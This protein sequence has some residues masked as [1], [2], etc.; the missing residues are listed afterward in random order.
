[1]SEENKAVIARLYAELS[2][3]NLDAIDTALADNFIEHEELPPGIPPGRE[4]VTAFF[5]V[6]RSAFPDL[7]MTPDFF[8][9]EG[10]LVTA[11]ATATGTHRGE[12]QGIPPTG[13]SISIKLADYMRVQNGKIVEHWGVMDLAGLMQQLGVGT[14]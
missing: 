13:K 5:G 6:I 7:N 12:F 3:G 11:F 10:D 1:M 8:I 14:P 2:K 4:G 9:A